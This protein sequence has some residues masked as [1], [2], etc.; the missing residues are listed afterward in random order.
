MVSN[1]FSGRQ[2]AWLGQVVLVLLAGVLV[3]VGLVAV[4]LSPRVSVV[5]AGLVGMEKA[6][7]AVGDVGTPVSLTSSCG[8]RDRVLGSN[9]RL[10]G[11]VAS[12]S[13]LPGVSGV[14]FE[15]PFRPVDGVAAEVVDQTGKVC[16]PAR[17]DVVGVG[18]RPTSELPASGRKIELPRCPASRMTF[19]ANGPILGGVQTPFSSASWNGAAYEIKYVRK[20]GTQWAGSVWEASYL[21]KTWPAFTCTGVLGGYASDVVVSTGYWGDRYF[22]HV[23]DPTGKVPLKSVVGGG[24]GAKN[25]NL[26]LADPVDS[27]TGGFLDSVVDLVVPGRGVG[28]VSGRSYDSRLVDDSVLGA[29]WWWSLVESV[30]VSGT[31][32]SAVLSWRGPTGGVVDF[33]SDGAGGFVTPAGFTHR[34]V[35]VAG[36]GWDV[37]GIDQVVSRF[38]GSGRL[39]RRH[40]RSGQGVSLSYEVAGRVASVRND[41]GA[42][43]TPTFGSSGP[44]NGRLVGLRTS[45]GRSVAFGYGVVGSAGVVR[46]VS[47]TDVSGAVWVYSYDANGFLSKVTDPLGHVVAANT[48]DALGRVV[49]QADPLGKVS[50]FSYDDTAGTTRFTDAAGAVRVVDRAGNVPNGLTDPAGGVSKTAFNAALDA[51]SFTDASGAAWSATYDGRGNMLTRTSPVGGVESW[52]YDALN[53]PLTHTDQRGF[54]TTYTYDTAGRVLS[55]TAPNGAVTRFVWNP[56][57]T[58]GSVTDPRGG[59]TRYTYDVFGNVLSV[60]SPVGAVSR[61]SYDAAG[62]VLSSTDPAGGVVRYTYDAAGRVLSVTSPVGAVST[63][64]YD[65]VGNRL[66]E[67]APDGGVTLF[68]YNAAN[69]LVSVTSPVGAVTRFEYSDRGEKIRQ[70]SADGGV[71]WAY[72]GSG[73]VVSMTEPLGNVAGAVAGSYTWRYA[74]DVAGR[75]VSTTDPTGRVTTASYDVA[76]RLVKRV[77]PAGTTMYTY[78]V[79]GNPLQVSD[80]AGTVSQVFDSVGRVSQVTNRRSKT[81]SFTYD[82]VGNLVKSVSPSGAVSTAVFDAANR[83]VA[84]TEPRG[85]VTGVNPAEYTS[86]YSYDAA[87]RLVSSTDPL[88]AVSR[89]VF[90]AAGRVTSSVDPKGTATTFTYDSVGRVTGVSAPL[91]G[92]TTYSYDLA[93][94]VTARTDSKAHRTSWA[95]DVM[96][97]A[98]RQTDPLGRFSTT[99]FNAGGEQTAA[100]DAVANAASNPALGTTSYG[101]DQLHRVVRRS[102]S[103]GTAA[104]SYVYD[105]AGRVGSMTDGTGSTSFAYDGANRVVSV[106]GPQGAFRYSYDA[107]GNVTQRVYPDSTNVTYTY[108]DDDRL[109]GV[110]RGTDQVSYGYLPGG[111]QASV[112]YSNGA[113]QQ[114]TYD[115]AGRVA[116][117]TGRLRDGSVVRS[118]TYVRDLNGFPT[119]LVIGTASGLSPD[120]QLLTYD[121]AGRVSSVCYTPTTACV[122]ANQ[123]VWTYDSVGNRVSEKTGGVLTTSLFDA[124]DQ[125]T[126]SNR[127]VAAPVLAQPGQVSAVEVVAVPDPET[128]AFSQPGVAGVAAVNSFRNPF[129]GRVDPVVSNQFGTVPT[130]GL[131]QVAGSGSPLRF[132]TP[133]PFSVASQLPTPAVPVTVGIVNPTTTS[134]TSTTTT[135]PVTTTTTTTSTSTTTTRPVT[136]TTSTTT[137]T[138]RPATTTTSTT[139][140]RPVTTTT[141]S[142]TTTRPVT[143]TTSTTTT[144]PGTTTTSTTRPGTTTTTTTR[145]GT[146]TTTTTRPGTTTTTTT[147]PGTTTTTTTRPGTT[148][149]T[150]TRPG[151]TTTTTRPT[152]T[153]TTTTVPP[154]VG[155]SYDANGAM[156]SG[157]GLRYTYNGAHQVKSVTDVAKNVTTSYVY[158]GFG[159]RVSAATNGVVTSR[160]VWDSQW[161]LPQLVVEQNGAGGFVRR[162]LY[163][164]G[165]VGSDT[166]A[167][168]SWMFTDHVGSVTNLLNGAGTVQASYVY[169]PFG[170]ERST[171]VNDPV[172]ATNPMRYTGEYRDGTGTYNLR[173]RQYNPGLGRFTQVDPLAPSSGLYPSAYVY[174]NNN[175]MVFTDPSGMRAKQGS[176]CLACFGHLENIGHSVISQIEKSYDVVR[177]P[178]LSSRMAVAGAR[179]SCRHFAD[180]DVTVRGV[181]CVAG[182]VSTAVGVEALTENLGS[183]TSFEHSGVTTDEARCM[184]RR[185][186]VHVATTYATARLIETAQTRLATKTG[187]CFKS[188]GGETLVLMADGST[189]PISEIEPGD[190][191]LAQDPET[192]EIGARKVT[193]AWVHDDDLVRLEIDGD[194]VRTTEDHPFWNDTDKQWQRADQLDSGDLVLTAEGRRVKVGMLIGSAGRGSAYNFTVE[195][196]HTY[197]VLFGTDAV[198]VHNACPLVE[199]AENGALRPEGG[200]LRGKKHGLTW[201]E[202]AAT[203]KSTGK[204]QGQWG[205]AADLDFA[206]NMAGSLAPGQ[207]GWFPAPPGT[208]SK[209][210][211]PDGSVVPATRIWVRNNGSGT[212]HGYPA[213]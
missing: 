159:N 53:S 125:L 106:S 151:T 25:K 139:T 178:V 35:G 10:L 205:S 72:D 13:P 8:L 95:Y 199:L 94:R 84:S 105:G 3:L 7:A 30:S 149:T 107:N 185:A 170:T 83:V 5:P 82:L 37:I 20:S 39:V 1:R 116:S 36:G 156:L 59:V 141:T 173:A 24:Y 179:E 81:S 29:G 181:D 42:V 155:Y 157:D 198:L 96:G 26:S 148:T 32:G 60:T 78:D 33:A 48:F 65:R 136:T 165:L 103:D 144:R 132:E 62:R 70:I 162:F 2:P 154:V 14:W 200:Y 58:L 164:N 100:V 196:L 21:N 201:G 152:T 64:T 17:I 51:T 79:A 153:T 76:G 122:A 44:A 174:G 184:Y 128:G 93:G 127:S 202:G 172:A 197:H 158:D 74:Y 187:P 114:S 54:V 104:V 206:G 171:V 89:T 56:D 211:L 117:I 203:A 71:T 18:P 55:E 209:V 138:T 166:T 208:T 88:G 189:K 160:F 168:T 134:T 131:G 28:L 77:S 143:T 135:R 97:R 40:D 192:G 108:D 85:N 67:K 38:D 169:T 15:S 11:W 163:G 73:R 112:G 124:A 41:S 193:H 190:M 118:N 207:S 9:G 52:T 133:M 75:L 146:T 147:R 212:F 68:G 175:P 12:A 110:G 61:F 57:G 161:S 213:P 27:A 43:L 80:P 183:C 46:L 142:T 115:R 194:I 91:V 87:G 188:F 113:T 102:Y 109:V 98:V 195:G 66:T 129:G 101:Y 210:F 145:P 120:S 45:D 23:E 126:R 99:S 69:E 49:S 19:D 63:Y 90:D 182:V 123:T 180:A 4:E 140:T 167:G 119:R 176:S 31:G 34:V 121:V 111:L 86:T 186:A 50:L 47:V 191:V 130:T 92:A 6:A 204:A 22:V 16:F 177:H 150:T 137:T